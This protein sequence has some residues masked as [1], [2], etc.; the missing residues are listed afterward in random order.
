MFK[1]KTCRGFRQSKEQNTVVENCSSGAQLITLLYSWLHHCQ[2]CFSAGSETSRVSGVET[3]ALLTSSQMGR[4]PY[5]KAANVAKD[6][7]RN[8][9]ANVNNANR[10]HKYSLSHKVEISERSKNAKNVQLSINVV[11]WMSTFF[12]LSLYSSIFFNM[13]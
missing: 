11:I 9:F 6:L 10:K 4:L 5:L 3:G 12:P 13:F 1:S 7:T 2:L 8:Q